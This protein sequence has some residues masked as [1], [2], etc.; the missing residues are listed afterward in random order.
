MELYLLAGSLLKELFISMFESVQ[1]ASLHGFLYTDHI[2]YQKR[3]KE[4]N[5]SRKKDSSSH[6]CAIEQA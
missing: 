5:L 1:K 3:A 2:T 4:N 6:C